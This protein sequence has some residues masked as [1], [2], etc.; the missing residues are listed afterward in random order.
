MSGKLHKR[1]RKFAKKMGDDS[2]EVMNVAKKEYKNLNTNE[3][4]TLNFQMKVHNRI[5]E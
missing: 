5:G 4:A 2:P 1:L 3:R